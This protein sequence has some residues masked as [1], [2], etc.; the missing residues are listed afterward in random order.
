[1]LV[2]VTRL[3]DLMLGKWRKT[4][5]K[6][7][8]KI[9]GIVLACF[10]AVVGVSVGVFAIQGGFKEHKINIVDLYLNASEDSESTSYEVNEAKTKLTI[11]TLT[12]VTT[13]IS[14]APL[15]ATE[16]NLAVTVT[17][18]DGVLA[19]KEELSEGVVAGKEFDIK[20]R[21]DA[22]GNN[23]GG[24]VNLTFKSS[25][26][27]AQVSIAV[28]VDVPIPSNTMYFSGDNNNRI[29]TTGKA[30]TLSKTT[31]TSYVYLKSELYNA[32]SLKV[33]G[34]NLNTTTGNLKSTEISYTYT[35]N[36]NTAVVKHTYT[37][38]ELKI[39]KGTDSLTHVSSYYY[40]IPIIPNKSGTIVFTAKTH[41]S[42]GIQQEFERD[43]VSVDEM[44]KTFHDAEISDALPA[45]ISKAKNLLKSFSAFVNKYIS[46]FDDTEESK[47]FFM[48]N[49]ADN[50]D[51][52]FTSYDS[53]RK[54]LNYVFVSCSAEVD[55]TAVNLDKIQSSSNAMTFNVFD[56]E[57]FSTS[58]FIV[59]GSET[60]TTT[61]IIDE[62]GL[63]IKLKGE[64]GESISAT[65]DENA[66]LFDSL[67]M[68][69]YIYLPKGEDEDTLLAN[70]GWSST[71]DAYSEKISVYG[72]DENDKPITPYIVETYP[73]NERED[74]V[75][76]IGYLYKLKTAMSSN[77]Y[78]DI[79]SYKN[80]TK[81]YWKIDFNIPLLEASN[82]ADITKA[83][84]FRFAVNGVDFSNKMA[85]IDRETFN[86]VYIDYTRYEFADNTRML[87][88]KSSETK[89]LNTTMALNSELAN[90]NGYAQS[91]QDIIVDTSSSSILNYNGKYVNTNT[92]KTYKEVE[93][94]NIMYF[95]ES[96]SNGLEG[97]A[98][99]VATLGK[100]NFIDIT[101]G[102]II[103]NGDQVL[104]GER[105]ATCNNTNDVKQFYIQTL[106]ASPLTD[107]VRTPVRVFAVVY[108]SDRAGNPITLDG[109]KIEVAD[110]LEPEDATTLYVV[111]MSDISDSSVYDIYINN[112]VDTINFYT[113][114]ASSITLCTEIE[115]LPGGI[116]YDENTWVKRNNTDKFTYS[117]SGYDVP[118]EGEML[119]E[120][121]DFLQLKLLKGKEFKIF[122][123]NFE[124]GSD[125]TVL[126]SVSE[127]RIRVEDIN[128]NEIAER[129]YVINS[130]D[131]KQIAFNNLISN[132]NNDFRLSVGQGVTVDDSQIKVDDDNTYIKFVITADNDD[133][134]GTISLQPNSTKSV[135]YSTTATAYTASFI[136]NHLEINDMEITEANYEMY[137]SLYAY[138]KTISSDDD[139]GKVE[140]K[141]NVQGGTDVYSPKSASEINYTVLTNLGEI[142]DGEFKINTSIV[143]P[144]QAVYDR[145]LEGETNIKEYID[146]YTKASEQGISNIKKNYSQVTKF[147]VLSD[148]LEI[149]K[150][151]YGGKI[152]W[153][154]G[155]TIIENDIKSET[156]GETEKSYL[157][158]NGVKYYDDTYPVQGKFQ[159]GTA[160]FVFPTNTYFPII[161]RTI[162]NE[163]GETEQ[164]QVMYLL[165][166]EFVL[167]KKIE[168]ANE[169]NVFYL[170][171]VDGTKGVSKNVNLVDIVNIDAK[172]IDGN[173]DQI[174]FSSTNYVSTINNGDSF[175]LVMG[176]DT[177]YI[178]YKDTTGEYRYDADAK[179]FKKIENISTFAGDRY[180]RHEQEGI[181]VY[182]FISFDFELV[183]TSI[184]KV[185]T[186]NLI[187]PNLNLDFYNAEG[188][189]NSKTNPLEINAGTSGNEISLEGNGGY[190]AIT[191]DDANV[192][193]H[194]QIINSMTGVDIVKGSD[195]LTISTSNLFGTVSSTQTF[196]I[197]YKFKNKIIEKECHISIK[198]NYNFE[199]LGESDASY[200]KL[201]LD[202]Y[203]IDTGT[204]KDCT[205]D[206]TNKIKAY[207][208]ATIFSSL[209]NGTGFET[210]TLTLLTNESSYS[211]VTFANNGNT[212]NAGISTIKNGANSE[213]LVFK[214][215]VDVNGTTETLA[216]KLRIEINPTYKVDIGDSLTADKTDANIITIFNGTNIYDYVTIYSYDSESKS[217]VKDTNVDTLVAISASNEDDATKTVTTDGGIVDAYVNG[218]PTAD[219]T[220]KLTFNYGDTTETRYVKVHG[221]NMF[222]SSTGAISESATL[223]SCK[224][225]DKIVNM[226]EI[227]GD[228]TLELPSDTTSIELTNY[229]V[230]FA[231]D[232][233]KLNVRLVD[234]SD[235]TKAYSNTLN[236]DGFNKTY[237]IYFEL[238]ET[239][240]PKYTT[241]I[242]KK[243]MISLATAEPDPTP[244]E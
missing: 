3:L 164:E 68:G 76:E 130:K 91:K 184:N 4:M 32:F 51:I 190:P 94:K 60:K 29:T 16:K 67:E 114:M 137:N 202:A 181:M 150:E 139:L 138:Y 73:A 37:A 244:S 49:V 145:E 88:L 58:E 127:K 196:K 79:N 160:K 146:A 232:G 178:Y 36:D 172:D 31:G 131:N 43:F 38:D 105:I 63:D 168:G 33:S 142:V 77:R 59:N 85:R 99:Q 41:R 92:G 229:F 100:Y 86:R 211:S 12:D 204:N 101:T 84:F 216:K 119:A 65:T 238:V 162:K 14:F 27:L 133:M 193:K 180:K 226:L 224:E 89:G 148:E 134:S 170:K 227:D 5:F 209:Y 90:A 124:L 81:T 96:T 95:V 113:V 175:E 20:I 208:L 11:Y 9:S 154:I 197:R 151:E 50:G 44:E 239:G 18:I 143:D 203:G 158:I 235:A 171:N 72:F 66:T 122:V 2:F 191:S 201:N 234:E 109:K 108:L 25:N 186:F 135:T 26:G 13:S 24:V 177:T 47:Y 215:T 147:A 121:K 228:I 220:I 28:V 69:V 206:D 185:L 225:N 237:K 22:L 207:D 102:T 169:Y 144:S 240:V 153:I 195:K 200:Y 82:E 56:E 221:I 159:D 217:Y 17:G 213:Y 123:T 83:L 6:R 126:D 157:E 75:D 187:Q 57:Y 48:N 230:F 218:I 155:S 117:D 15:D 161:T 167:E 210:C 214:I 176:E 183:G 1:M 199:Y 30:F 141:K 39:V 78:M 198:P 61:N 192:F 53:A 112:F 174:E 103:A 129:G 87:S 23:H 212:L 188:E 35:P 116:T 106:N 111:A 80:G 223:D 173:H 118:V 152:V 120:Y 136:V 236:T 128:G 19:N 166:E 7:I 45:N 34:D 46:Y 182:L 52:A 54:A 97:G 149:T 219:T 74:Y 98:K 156:V 55:V 21:K 93:Y 189:L 8:M 71:S 107:G 64:N 163:Q 233:T 241:N 40:K 165:G 70:M 179:A 42:Y 242:G 222:Y 115:E 104:E 132:F 231:N 10:I 140:F 110:E 243:I 125:G 205:L 62:F 194:I